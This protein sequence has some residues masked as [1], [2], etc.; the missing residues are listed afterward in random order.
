MAQLNDWV[1]QV[2]ATPIRRSTVLTNGYVAASDIFI[3]DAP[4]NQLILYVDFTKGSLTTAE[5][6]VEFSATG[7]SD[8]WYQETN[9]VITTAANLATAAN[10]VKI[11]QFAATGK[12]RLAI[13]IKDQYIRVSA[14]GTGT[15]TN[16]LMA[17]SAFTGVA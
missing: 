16:S 17:I 5:I 10:S 3:K 1:Y 14:N 9:E 2:N 15:V 13:P 8:T 12:Y 11:H 6:K 4:H 7:E